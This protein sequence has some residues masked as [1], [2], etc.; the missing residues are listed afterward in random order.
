[1]RAR[2]DLATHTCAQLAQLPLYPT[3]DVLWD[4]T[5]LPDVELCA[6]RQSLALPK[7]GLQFVS[8]R[9]YFLRNFELFR[10]SSTFDVR[11]D[12]EDAIAR[13]AP[14]R[15]D[16][17]GDTARGTKFAGVARMAVPVKACSVE[18]VGRPRV[19]ELQPSS[20]HAIVGACVCVCVCVCVCARACVCVC[21]RSHHEAR[22]TD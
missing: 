3:D 7:L 2:G 11:L 4:A 8:L 15:V 14:A 22:A 9:D 20:V 10:M 13:L 21:R 17:R 18:R 6:R 5:R 16:A 1:V 12:V 19:G